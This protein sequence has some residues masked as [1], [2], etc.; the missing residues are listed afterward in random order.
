M[1]TR[2]Q[3]GNQLWKKRSKSGIDKIFKTPEDMWQAACEYF[4]YTDTRVWNK[5][6]YKGKDIEEVK[7]PTSVPYTIKG[8]C[9]FLGVNEKYFNNFE[10]ELNESPEAN[11]FRYIIN[12]IKDII[13]TQKFEGAVVGTYNSNIIARDLGLRE[14]TDIT[15]DDQ[16]IQI[17]K[18]GETEIKF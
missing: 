6:D 7:I 10:R 11:D 14:K 2:F 17:F 3:E 4:E 12:T 13:Y 16:P 8:M 18:I 5:I 1:G 9:I 15:S